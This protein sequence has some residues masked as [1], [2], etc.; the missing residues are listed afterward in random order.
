MRLDVDNQQRMKTASAFLLEFYKIIMG[1]FLTVFVPRSCPDGACSL[2]D[3]IY[4]ESALHR[5]A[6]GFN[7]ATFVAFLA[8]YAIELRRENWCI[9]YLDI[10]PEKPNENLDD[11]IEAYPII[12]KEMTD[13]NK[14]YQLITKICLVA[15][16]MNV[17]VS[18]AD[19]ADHWAG[20]A[21]ITPLLSYIL[22]VFIKLYSAYNVSN[23]AVKDERAFSAYIIGPKTYNTIDEDHKRKEAE[24]VE[25][26][27]VEDLE[28]NIEESR[29]VATSE[30]EKSKAV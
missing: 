23:I 27:K 17:G 5:V 16:T 15:Q 4:D 11:E 7:G 26:V 24:T 18:V 9:K 2:T 12:K 25:V 22:L 30:G 1:A 8:F 3:N 20:G 14:Q 19:I 28:V 13:L 21:T 29:D 6:L 10:D